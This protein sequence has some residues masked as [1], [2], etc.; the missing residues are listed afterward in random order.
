[1]RIDKAFLNDHNEDL[2]LIK[3]INKHPSLLAEL[4]K[5]D[6]QRKP[7][8]PLQYLDLK[9]VLLQPGRY[10]QLGKIFS[11]VKNK[12]AGNPVLKFDAGGP[13]AGKTG[14]ATPKP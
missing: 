5:K 3:L 7:E 11:L 6:L 10:E 1:V 4:N 13:P 9:F 2:K 8:Q 14:A 12:E